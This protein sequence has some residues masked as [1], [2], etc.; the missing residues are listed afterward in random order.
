MDDQ[1][2]K[3]DEYR[4][5]KAEGDAY[6]EP[7]HAKL[8]RE[9]S[10]ADWDGRARVLVPPSAPGFVIGG[11]LLG[12]PIEWSSDVTEPTIKRYDIPAEPT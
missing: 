3:A 12:F 4:R 9:A 7:F 6:F 1:Q 11:R 8:L 10:E 5:Q 2:R